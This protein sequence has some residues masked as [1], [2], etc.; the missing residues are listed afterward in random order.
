MLDNWLL[1]F[2]C[3]SNISAN[4]TCPSPLQSSEYFPPIQ[5]RS[6]QLFADDAINDLEV[7]QFTAVDDGYGASVRGPHPSL[8]DKVRGDRHYSTIGGLCRPP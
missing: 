7:L 3:N 4:H 1:E 8:L 5:Q 2:E 6:T